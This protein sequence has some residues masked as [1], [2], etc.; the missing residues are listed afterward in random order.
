MIENIGRE[1]A[2]AW[3]ILRRRTTV[4]AGVVAILSIGIT[5]AAAAFSAL[6]AGLLND[7][8]YPDQDRLVL[9]HGTAVRT[10]TM[11]EWETLSHSYEHLA[12]VALGTADIPSGA[13]M[14]EA[15]TALVSN[16]LFS[17]LGVNT[18]VG[19][20]FSEADFRENGPPV[21]ILNNSFA[22]KHFGSS[23]NAIG[24]LVTLD[25]VARQ[26]VGVL[27]A[28][29]APLP[30]KIDVWLPLIKTRPQY[31]DGIAILHKGGSLASAQLE[32][33]S[34]AKRLPLE[35]R[36]A[37]VTVAGLKETIVKDSRQT[38][39]LLMVATIL[40]LVIICSNAASLMLVQIASREREF[41]MR[42]A[43]GATRGLL[44]RQLF[45]ET[46]LLTLCATAS[47][48][49]LSFWLIHGAKRIFPADIPRLPEAGFT[50]SVMA[51]IFL[52][53]ISAAALISCVLF[54]IA[55]HFASLS[56]LT[57]RLHARRL[58]LRRGIFS[59]LVA[60]EVALTTMLL[61]GTGLL[62][63][64]F[65][66]LAPYKP[67]FEYA[68]K[69]V[70][71]IVMPD[72]GPATVS[73]R[74]QVV[75]EDV[76]RYP[77]VSGVA[78][79]SELPLTDTSWVPN[80][81]MD[82]NLIAGRRSSTFIHCRASTGN[83]FQLMGIPILEGR[84]FSA[85]PAREQYA[86]V[87]HAFAQRVGGGKQV[88]GKGITIDID[89][90]RQAFVI[91][92]VASNIRMFSGTTIAEPELYIPIDQLALK[93]VSLVA[94]VHNTSETVILDLRNLVD[95]DSGANSVLVAKPLEQILAD[96]IKT[97][98]ARATMFGIIAVIAVLL[99]AA[100][101]YGMLSWS[102][103]VGLREIRT[104]LGAQPHQIVAFVLRQTVL[105]TV[106]GILVGISGAVLAGR[107]MV[108]LLYNTKPTDLTP[109][110]AAALITVTI[111]ALASAIPARR[112]TRVDPLV[113]MRSE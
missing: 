49:P 42:V 66:K 57:E 43:L 74:L 38:L 89:G 15:S 64:S 7:L 103:E 108:T 79:T 101:I 28:P 110:A 50:G 30:Y 41:A 76:R 2:I 63:E 27:Y 70:L 36:V 82:G 95:K 1:L 68:D 21:A 91:V 59:V 106:A 52:A 77:G 25:G 58:S 16:R 67:G 96:S 84:S 33:A 34:I 39:V 55:R 97:P 18:A 35:G 73:S 19:R 4:M 45:S 86:V 56:A 26:V 6:E 75:M 9:L 23:G 80:V 90:K 93:R 60:A 92:G 61:V 3:R 37:T 87:N 5:I 46:L 32:A 104:A 72:A 113:V 99:A 12:F 31:A 100:G 29:N 85:V 44:F 102:I 13:A 81:W 78:A 65:I 24:K 22:D 105:V 69:L 109:I 53:G 47:A 112:A 98:R 107:A 11:Q 14:L 111:S 8:P 83:F 71:R 51:F 20:M 54:G 94:Q 10:D 17:M 48:V 40:L 62:V 88:L